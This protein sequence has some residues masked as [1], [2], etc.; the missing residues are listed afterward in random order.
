[1]IRFYQEVYKHIAKKLPLDEAVVKNAQC[2]HTEVKDQEAALKMIPRLA[3]SLPN[4]SK[5]EVTR[6]S[7][8]WKMYR[9]EEISDELI[10]DNDGSIKRIDHY[11]SEVLDRKSAAG[12]LKFP[13]LKKV[14][15]SCLSL[16]HGNAN[17]ERSLSINKK[18]H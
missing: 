7:D 9:E 16:F 13:T 3:V 18:K 1:M 2:L 8:E 11:W 5:E 17:V 10:Y 12:L 15:S 14:A 6:V 4:I